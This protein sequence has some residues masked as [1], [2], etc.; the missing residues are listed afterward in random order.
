MK[1]SV[2]TL[3]C[4]VNRYE[5]EAM[6]RRLFECGYEVSDKLEY[7]D[8]YIINTCSVTAEAD[9]KS[10]QAVARVLK[11]NPSAL[12]YIM[13]CSSQYDFSQFADKPNVVLISGTAAKADMLE[14]IIAGIAP[15]NYPPMLMPPLPKKYEEMPR[16]LL[17][18][19]RALLKVQDGCDNFCSYCVIPHLRGRSRSRSIESVVVEAEAASVESREIVLIGINLSAY[20]KDMGLS[21]SD[22]VRALGKIN[23]RKRLGSLECDVIDENLLSAMGESGFCEHFHLSLQSGSDSVLRAMNRRYDSEFYYERTRLIRKF[24]PNAGITTDIICGFPT[25]TDE[26]HRTSLSFVEK[27]GFSDGHVFV[28]SPRAGTPAAKMRQIPPEQKNRRA[29]EMSGV[30]EKSRNK[31]LSEQSGKVYPVYVEEIENGYGVGYTPNYIKTYSNT[32]KVK[33]IINLRLGEIYKEGVK[34]Y[35]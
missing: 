10:R 20:G 30:I 17:P 33:E 4:K 7:A 28:F 12:V 25:E 14:N 9:K 8:A 3:G 35:E 6:M 2:F 27:V 16:P 22:L 26:N 34:A 31:F 32:D 13:G 24:F 5:S 21:L 1:F 29:G 18:A 23:A 15:L 19:T 11:H